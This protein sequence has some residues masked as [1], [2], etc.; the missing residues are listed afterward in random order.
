MRKHLSWVIVI[1]ALACNTLAPRPAPTPL[2]TVTALPTAELQASQ[3]PAS[4]LTPTATPTPIPQS[5]LYIAPGDVLIHPDPHIY[6][7]DKVSFEVFAHDGAKIGLRDFPVGLYAGA[8][9][10]DTQLAAEPAS[11]YGLG[12]RL[13]ATFIWVWDTTDLVGPQTLTIVL[14]PNGEIRNGD[15][16][17]ENNTLAFTVNILPRAELAASER[18]AEWAT[19]ETEC[20]LFNYITGSAAERDLDLITAAAQESLVYV[21]EKM[22]RAAGQK[23]VFNLINRLLGHGGFAADTVTITYIDRDYAGGGLE[24]VFRHE[25]AHVL[26]RAFGDHRPALIEEGTAT[27]IAGGHFK[28]E[29][30]EPRMVGVLALDRYIPLQQLADDFYNSQHE[31]GYLE[32][33]AFVQYLV[34]AYGWENFE[35]FLAAFQ[36]APR[37]SAMLDAGLRLV[38]DKS[39][40][41][42]EA[43][44]LA[45]LR[46]QPADERWRADIDATVQYFDTIRRYQ[47]A[48]DPSAHF[49]TA[50]I[51][52]IN[53]AVRE[54]I[55]ADYSRHPGA[56]ENI[57]LETMLIEVDRA[58]EGG[59]YPAAARYL[60]AVNAVLATGDFGESPLATMYLQV[61]RAAHAAGYEPQRIQ[62]T[63]GPDS[64]FALVTASAH[65]QPTTLFEIKLTQENGVWRMN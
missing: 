1:A 35:T 39:L 46:T 54:D 19:A 18:E 47:Q 4:T 29:P 9:G 5:D 34:D 15:E 42:V 8:P 59:D 64:I 61:V 58:I 25:A 38:Y 36:P 33:A 23:M 13:Q 22:G 20:C 50:W 51:P 60:S 57:A 44:W 52:D 21:E 12:E 37:D 63:A 6:S 40:A 7:G 41:G 65:A 31:I 49:L 53:R 48:N 3:T 24:N 28:E 30:F 17:K 56:P 14:D 55:V 26:N 16:N 32:G 10:S 62:I 43:E 2:P 11:P 27:Y 45:H